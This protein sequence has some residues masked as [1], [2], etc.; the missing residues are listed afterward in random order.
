MFRVSFPRYW[1]TL[2]SPSSQA[3]LVSGSFPIG[4]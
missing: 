3:R 2:D 4:L 1:E